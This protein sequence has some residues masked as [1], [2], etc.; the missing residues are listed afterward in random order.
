MTQPDSD[1][2][3]YFDYNGSTPLAG[4]VRERCSA[5]LGATFGNSA[6]PHPE[7][8]AAAQ[9]VGEARE[10]VAATLGAKPSEVVFTSGGTESNNFALF[11]T[12]ARRSSGHLVVTAIE[13]RSVLN[14]ALALEQRGFDLTLVQPRSDGAVHLRDVQA[15]LRDDT[16]LVS[17]MWANNETGITQPVREIGALCRERDIRFHTDAVCAFGK[18]AVRVDEVP[19]DMLS[20]SGHKLYSPKGVGLLYLREG[21]EIEPLFYGCGHQN[22]LRSGT[23]NTLGVAG[24]GEACKLYTTG[25]LSSAYSLESLRQSLW[26]GIQAE[27]PGAE[28]NGTGGSLPNTLNVYFPGAPAA[29]VQAKLAA[30]GFSVAAGASASTGA[31]SHVLLAMGHSSERASQSLRF[32]LGLWSTPDGVK[33]LLDSLCAAVESCRPQTEAFA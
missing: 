25:A 28:R 27:I 8:R 7:G 31:A 32:S 1:L 22:G 5:L 15:A 21:T 18:L 3:R 24:F 13:H 4:P 19:C 6:A 29:E 9:L 33:H 17:V 26:N 11:G 14:A 16:F 10:R 2:A 20:L 30:S 23:E 12:A